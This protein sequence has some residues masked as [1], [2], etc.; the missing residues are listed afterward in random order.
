MINVLDERTLDSEKIK[1]KL[2]RNKRVLLLTHMLIFMCM[3]THSMHSPQ[4]ACGPSTYFAAFG[5]FSGMRKSKPRSF[6]SRN[7]AKTVNKSIKKT[8]K[9]KNSCFAVIV[10]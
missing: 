10:P 8:K 4:A 2:F 3:F 9:K 6:T 7:L 5:P 1:N